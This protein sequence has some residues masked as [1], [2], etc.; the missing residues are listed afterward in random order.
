M[1]DPIKTILYIAVM[2]S[3]MA[4]IYYVGMV[5]FQPQ[6][7]E[8]VFQS[9]AEWRDTTLWPIEAVDHMPI[10]FQDGSVTEVSYTI[11]LPQSNETRMKL[12]RQCRNFETL[13]NNIRARI[14]EAPNIMGFVTEDSVRVIQYEVRYDR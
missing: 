12:A 9:R 4:L 3:I 10:R 1:P 6:T 13:R 14:R 8:V 11:M 2:C 7:E 5:S